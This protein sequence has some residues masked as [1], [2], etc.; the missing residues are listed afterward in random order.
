MAPST[1]PSQFSE[2]ITWN[3]LK[4]AIAASSGFQRWRTERELTDTPSDL[5]LEQLVSRYLRETLET[6][7][8]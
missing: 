3:S 6:L 7:A 2:D 1:T 4:R 8:Y 5:S